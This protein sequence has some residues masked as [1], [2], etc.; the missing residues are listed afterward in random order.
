MDGTWLKPDL[1][2]DETAF[3]IGGG[4]SLLEHDLRR[5]T[6]RKVIVTNNA[7][8]IFP[9]AQILH[10]ADHVWYTWHKEELKTFK[11]HITCSSTGYAQSAYPPSIKHLPKKSNKGLSENIKHLHGNNAGH[12]AINLAVLLGAKNIILLGFDMKFVGGK[13]HW[14]NDH[15]RPTPQGTYQNTMIPNLNTVAPIVQDMGINIYN[16]YAESALQ[17]FP[18]KSFDECARLP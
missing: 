12:Q 15:K 5:I 16:T 11:G 14:H 7:Y 8:R 4:P 18:F 1:W 10:F 9:E 17:C 13:S 6:G 3:I 2:K